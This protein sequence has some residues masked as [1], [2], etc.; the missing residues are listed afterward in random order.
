MEAH[1]KLIRVLISLRR[2][3][4]ACD[5]IQSLLVQPLVL[6]DIEKIEFSAVLA[7]IHERVSVVAPPRPTQCS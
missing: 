1:F 2:A 4:D 5:V 6:N 3:R 7:S